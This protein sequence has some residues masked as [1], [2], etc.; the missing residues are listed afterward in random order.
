MSEEFET[1][2]NEDSKVV[3]NKIA[4]MWTEEE[5][6]RLLEAIE[7]YGERGWKRIALAVGTRDHTKCL[8]RWKKVLKP[9]L[10]KGRWS[11]EED[12]LLIYLVSQGYPNW[13]KLAKN[14]PGRTSKQCRERWCHFL[15]PNL[16][17]PKGKKFTEQ[18]DELI[19]QLQ[20]EHGN[21]WS[22]ISRQLKGRTH[23]RF[24]HLFR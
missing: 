3:G 7:A 23:V 24:P 4:F 5:D 14:L 19:L 20:K 16:N 2:A 9:D 10:V 6:A 21:S 13:G 22:F 8:Q 11:S 15:D 17:A 18:E 1:K 12:R